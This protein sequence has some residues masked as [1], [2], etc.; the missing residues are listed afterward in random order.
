MFFY[1]CLGVLLSDLSEI[2]NKKFKNKFTKNKIIRFY[3][4]LISIFLKTINTS[5]T[6]SAITIVIITFV[7]TK[8]KS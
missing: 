1:A 8:K 4:N 2:K 3:F 7:T 5:S 6:N